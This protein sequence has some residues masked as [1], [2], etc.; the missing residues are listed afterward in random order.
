MTDIQSLKKLWAVL[1]LFLIPFGGGI[2]V[3]VLRAQAFAIAW[4]VTAVLYFISDVILA[5][6]FEPVMTLVIVAVG[7]IPRLATAFE[8][9]RATMGRTAQR[10]GVGAGPFAL[11]MVAFGVDPMTGRAAAAVAGHGFL[12]GWAIAITGDMLY[13]AVIMAATL[14]LRRVFQNPELVVGIIL[15]AMVLLPPIIRNVAKKIR[16]TSA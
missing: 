4:P 5:L 9:M 15:L 10:Y 7:K 14:R 13:F 3:G 1:T 8:A 12:A 2:P 6:L 11:V 16:W